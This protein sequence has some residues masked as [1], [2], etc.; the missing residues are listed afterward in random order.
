[1]SERDHV[2]QSTLAGGTLSH[3]IDSAIP[4]AIGPQ[5]VVCADLAASFSDAAEAC[6]QVW[7]P[8]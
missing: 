2:V 7:A 8:R 1:M 4:R 5:A 6:A 3:S